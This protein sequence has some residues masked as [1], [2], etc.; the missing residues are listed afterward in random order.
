[1]QNM[2]LAVLFLSTTLLAF[3][4]LGHLE[5]G[6]PERLQVV[7]MTHTHGPNTLFWPGDPE[8]HFEIVYRG[9]IAPGEW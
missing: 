6:Q 5:K 1:M 2:R 7:D 4:V 3:Q 9:E 8:Y